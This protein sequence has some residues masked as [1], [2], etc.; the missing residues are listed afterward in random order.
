MIEGVLMGRTGHEMNW[1]HFCKFDHYKNID[2]CE[3][4][5][6]VR[7]LINKEFKSDSFSG[8][9]IGL[10]VTS[11]WRCKEWEKYRNRSGNSQHVIAAIDVVPTNVS[12]A[13]SDRIVYFLNDTYSNEVDGW[14]GGFAISNPGDSSTGFAHFDVR[15]YRARWTY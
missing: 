11:G 3:K 4:M 7:S 15:G 13:V 12:K 14:M 1:S 8:K 5:E 2:L 9:D 6:V 10:M